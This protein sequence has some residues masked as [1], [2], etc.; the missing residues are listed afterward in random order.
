MGSLNQGSSPLFNGSGKLP[1][2]VLKLVPDFLREKGLEAGGWG[3]HGFD[4][5]GLKGKS[6]DMTS[7]DHAKMLVKSWKLMVIQGKS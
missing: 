4:A 6:W 3:L 1:R 5:P 7:E 2:Q